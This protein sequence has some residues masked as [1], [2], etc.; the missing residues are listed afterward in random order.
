MVKDVTS[1]WFFIF[2]FFHF[3]LIFDF[4]FFFDALKMK[5]L[6]ENVKK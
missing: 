6:I 5:V 1:F 3:S 4:P 2:P